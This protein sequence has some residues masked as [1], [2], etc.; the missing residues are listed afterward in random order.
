MRKQI[1]LAAAFVLSATAVTAGPMD[2]HTVVVAGYAEQMVRPDYATVRVG[3]VTIERTTTQAL[4][5]NTALMRKVLDAI[6]AEG[7]PETAI[8]TTDFSIRAQ[9]PPRKGEAYGEDETIT[10][11]YR[12]GNTLT[13]MV[14]DLKKIGRVIDAATRAGANMS[15]SVNF[16]VK[17]RQALEAKLLADAVRDARRNAEI[18]AAAEN[19]KVGRLIAVSNTAPVEPRWSERYADIGALRRV[20]DANLGGAVESVVVVEGVVPVSAQVMAVYALE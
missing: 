12:V 10:T 1:W 7:I 13:V 17:D 14:T 16:E 15:G 3:V 19:A 18:M 6:K 20:P 5:A 4:D 8:Q 2:P 9:H 11:G